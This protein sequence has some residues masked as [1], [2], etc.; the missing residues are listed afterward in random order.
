VRALINLTK[1]G[2]ITLDEFEA[3]IE[4]VVFKNNSKSDKTHVVIDGFIKKI[5]PTPT[6]ISDGE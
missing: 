6:V 4:C 5:Q 3:A 2:G 1:Q